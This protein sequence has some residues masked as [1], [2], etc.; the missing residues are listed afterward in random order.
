MWW[1]TWDGRLKGWMDRRTNGWMS[2][3]VGGWMEVWMDG[4]L[5]GLIFRWMDVFPHISFSQAVL[6]TREVPA[7]VLVDKL[8]AAHVHGQIWWGNLRQYEAT[9]VVYYNPLSFHFTSQRAAPAA[10][11]QQDEAG[12]S[13]QEEVVPISRWCCALLGGGK[14]FH[15]APP[16]SHSPPCTRKRGV[17]SAHV[18]HL[19]ATRQMFE[20]AVIKSARGHRQPLAVKLQYWGNKTH[21]CPLCWG[22]HADHIKNKSYYVRNRE[23]GVFF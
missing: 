13:G 23:W 8:P 16:P 22:R 3:C 11:R 10:G 21:R 19:P 4:S 12:G 1:V 20:D 15:W 2:R 18:P 5:D 6:L 9:H 7:E 14:A 17:P